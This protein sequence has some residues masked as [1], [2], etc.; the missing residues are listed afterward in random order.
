[1]VLLR[2]EGLCK[3]IK[4]KAIEGDFAFQKMIAEGHL[5]HY[6]DDIKYIREHGNEWI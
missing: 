1:M 6:Q 4:K 3:T 5:E 2:L